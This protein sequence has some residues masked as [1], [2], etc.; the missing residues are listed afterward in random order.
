VPANLRD[1]TVIGEVVTPLAEVGT[2]EPGEM[3]AEVNRS[4]GEV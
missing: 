1:M 4:A 3:V 2:C